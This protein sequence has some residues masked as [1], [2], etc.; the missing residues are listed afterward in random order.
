MDSLFKLSYFANL[1]KTKDVEGYEDLQKRI[2]EKKEYFENIV[3]CLNKVENAIKDCLNTIQ[4]SNKTLES[5][6]LSP[7]E[8]NIQDI[9]KSIYQKIS[10]SFNENLLLLKQLT[11]QISSHKSN[12]VKELDYYSELKRINKD[13]QDEKEKLN[14]NKETYHKLGKKAEDQ[15]KEYIKNIKNIDD[16]YENEILRIDLDEMVDPPRT[17]LSNYISSLSKTNDLIKKYNEK[18]SL[19]FRYLPQLSSE[20]GVFCFRLIKI[21]LQSLEKENQFLVSKIDP[22]KNT[23][24]L[25]TKTKLIEL[26]ELSENNKKEEKI[27]KLMDYQ[28]DLDLNKCETEKEFELY[29]NTITIIKNFIDESLF[30]NFNYDIDV[31]NFR[32]SQIIKK[33]FKEKGEIDPKLS[34]D[35]LNLLNDSTI[36]RGVFI[37]LSQLRTN[38]KFLRTKFLI[39]LLG[40]GFN[41]LLEKAIENKL[42]ENVKNCIILSQ[43]YYYND[44]NKNKIY[45]FE[46]IKNSKYLINSQ[47]WRIFIENMIKT[48]FVRFQTVFP[49]SNFNVEKNINITNKIK[50]KL[51]EVVF[52]QLL[53]YAS[54]MKDFNIDKRIIVKIVDEFVEK[55]NYI[56]KNNLDNLYEMITQGEVD[57]EK[58]RKE[59][60][61]SLEDELIDELK[62]NDE[63]RENINNEEK[64]EIINNEKEK[65]DEKQENE[66]KKNK[67]DDNNENNIINEEKKDNI[68][69]KTE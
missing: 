61:P 47:F 9:M 3:P 62:I 38:S 27:L 55:Y 40:K 57:I 18:Q 12:L 25:E 11:S 34:E 51:N 53:T 2:T 36:H 37:I 31:K 7:E 26:I 41:I 21:F 22:I 49:E 50:D 16:I 20:E 6:Q 8:K 32:M 45:I 67:E 48:E 4:N 33:L 17:A 13:L 30:P 59:Y 66:E 60:D 69:E 46:Y 52:S 14:K 28:T 56:S 42:S 5:I 68:N 15:I 19:L 44:E 24:N 54:N 65:K 39:D 29:S 43:T 58:L 63:K 1:F 23:N 64:K 10:N 35:F